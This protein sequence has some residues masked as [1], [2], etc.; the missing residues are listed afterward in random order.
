M[1]V[2]GERQGSWHPLLTPV[3]MTLSLLCLF[4]EVKR[5]SQDRVN[6]TPLRSP[7]E[8]Q[9]GTAPGNHFDSQHSKN[10]SDN[11]KTKLHKMSASCPP[12]KCMW[13]KEKNYL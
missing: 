4:P 5:H 3:L 11:N 1:L 6:T 13:P 7:N 9:R 10:S 8:R 12:G 2:G